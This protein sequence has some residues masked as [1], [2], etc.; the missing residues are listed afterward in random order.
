MESCVAGCGSTPTSVTFWK[1]VPLSPAGLAPIKRELRGDIFG[2]EIA[3]ARAHAAAFEQIA[4]QK[5]HVRAN[6]LAG[7]FGHLGEKRSSHRNQK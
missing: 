3:S 1:Y 7:D 4:R 2:G 6:A 5:L